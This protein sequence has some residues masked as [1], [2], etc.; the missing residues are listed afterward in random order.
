M[1]GVGMQQMS[2]HFYRVVNSKLV[3]KV[4]CPN[5]SKTAGLQTQTTRLATVKPWQGKATGQ[6]FQNPIFWSHSKTV[7]KRNLSFGCALLWTV[8]LLG[9]S[10]WKINWRTMAMFVGPERKMMAPSIAK[11]WAFMSKWWRILA[12]QK[13][14]CHFQ[15]TT[16]CPKI[17]QPHTPR[18]AGKFGGPRRGRT[19]DLPASRSKKPMPIAYWWYESC[20]IHFKVKKPASSVDILYFAN[21]QQCFQ[22]QDHHTQTIRL[23]IF[24]VGNLYIEIYRKVWEVRPVYTL[25]ERIAS[26]K[27][28]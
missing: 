8:F 7:C 3:K 20:V 6:K 5:L 23:W 11:N 27:Q 9:V 24:S 2:H 28:I 22:K 10:F 18:A 16:L 13:R 12:K 14:S 26:Q 15:T 4:T 17:G 25:P 19:H 1:K 21:H